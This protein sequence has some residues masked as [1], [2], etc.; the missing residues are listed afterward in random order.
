MRGFWILCL[1]FLIAYCVCVPPAST[2]LP[3][4]GVRP[5][6]SVVRDTAVRWNPVTRLSMRVMAQ[7]RVST[8]ELEPLQ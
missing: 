6:G 7:L 4:L 2:E 8:T 5:V 1:A 3:R